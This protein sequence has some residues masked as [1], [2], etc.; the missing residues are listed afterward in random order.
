MIEIIKEWTA[1]KNT[2]DF[3]YNEA[4]KTLTKDKSIVNQSIN[5]YLHIDDSNEKI[6]EKFYNIKCT[7]KYIKEILELINEYSYYLKMNN[8]LEL[9]SNQEK[10]NLKKLK[11]LNKILDDDFILFLN[12]HI[13]LDKTI[14][15]SKCGLK[16]EDN[17]QDVIKH[18]LEFD[19]KFAISN[20][21]KYLS[22]PIQKNSINIKD[23]D[24][25][26]NITSKYKTKVWLKPISERAILK[27]LYF[28]LLYYFKEISKE[29]SIDIIKEFFNI[30]LEDKK[31]EHTFRIGTIKYIKDNKNLFSDDINEDIKREIKDITNIKKAIND[32]FKPILE[33][34]DF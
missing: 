25:T 28:D 21:Y 12:N 23:S 15:S 10:E 3:D 18:Y 26:N 11:L 16:I 29:Q 14:I 4:L 5:K 2:N 34:E 1:S 20:L 9:F 31:I 8:E 13:E 6:E 30:I 32:N 17:Y 22:Y 33:I 19:F 27:C 24:L 7:D